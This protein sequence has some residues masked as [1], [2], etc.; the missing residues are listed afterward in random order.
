MSVIVARARRYIVVDDIEA[1]DPALCAI[2]DDGATL[3]IAVPTSVA[4]EG[5]NHAEKHISRGIAF[6]QVCSRGCSA[7]E[8]TGGQGPSL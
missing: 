5:L 6:V 7:L 8:T 4:A 1:D 3:H 2:V